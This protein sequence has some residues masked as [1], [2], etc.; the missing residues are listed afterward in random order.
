MYNYLITSGWWCDNDQ[1]ENRDVK[2]G[3]SQQRQVDFFGRW[4]EVLMENTNPQRIV[5]V[6]SASPI[7]PNYTQFEKVHWIDL[8]VNAGHATRHTGKYSG[9]VH[10]VITGMLFALLADVDYWVYV[11]QDALISG[12][13]IIEHTIFHM[14]GGIMF[15][16]G[17]GTPQ[18]LQQSFMIFQKDAL[19]RF[20]NN[21]FK[22]HY[23][24]KEISPEVKFAIAS[25]SLLT[26]Y[27]N[28]VCKLLSQKKLVGIILRKLFLIFERSRFRGWE[29][30]PFGYGRARPINHSDQYYYFQHGT[31][32][33]IK[34]FSQ[35]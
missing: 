5:V 15:G 29:S 2:Y 25:S 23:K 16:S 24:D 18:P 3:S 4:Y 22:I 21:F 11:E 19:A 33:E 1:S 6:D 13:G 10:G 28:A 35:K 27:P 12:N 14:K 8:P 30:L 26:I 34:L 32:E 17:V 20:I 9:Y 31:D 7:K